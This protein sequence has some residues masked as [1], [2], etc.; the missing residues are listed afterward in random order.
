MIIETERL[1][2]RP[3]EMSDST[4]LFQYGSDP[5]IGPNAGWPPLK[6][7]EE[8]KKIIE[9]ILSNWGFYA[10]VFKETNE[11][12]GCINILIGEASNFDIADDEGELGFWIGVPHWGNG[13]ATEAIE[14]MLDYGFEDLELKK[15][16]CGYFSD[17]ERSRSVQE[18]C[19]FQYQYTLEKIKTLAG[20]EKTEIVM[21]MENSDYYK[22]FE[23]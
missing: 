21:G 22:G 14:E 7:T 8:S 19:G 4:A 1:I 3:W 11:I 5:R 20:D 23:K 6:N 9:L 13:Y 16:W 15:I 2:L 12:V 18:K 10:I 17:N